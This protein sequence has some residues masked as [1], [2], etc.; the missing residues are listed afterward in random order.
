M[1]IDLAT[2]SGYAAYNAMT[3]TIVPRPVAWVLS[4]NG[5]GGYNL[6]P[7]SYFNALTSEPPLITLS[8]G[9]K[10]DG[11][12]KDTL[13]NI[14]T[15]NHLVIHIPHREQAV[16][17]THSA[18]PLA[19][20]DSEI[21]QLGL[22]LTEFP[23]FSLPRLAECRIAIGCT[24]YQTLE[25]GPRPQSLVVC[26]IQSLWI[27]DNI[28]DSPADAP[29]HLDARRLDPLGRLGGDEYVTLGEIFTVTNP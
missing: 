18:A 6:A 28:I 19:H 2:L 16:A 23:G 8:I 15:R 29:L 7:F 10:R 11:E 17:V 26:Q 20:G 13:H 22:E 27:D 25:I 14:V 1:I 4:D 12:A 24:H 21:A 5:D 3:Q 9:N